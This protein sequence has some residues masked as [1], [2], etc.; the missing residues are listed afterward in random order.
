MRLTRDDRLSPHKLHVRWVRFGYQRKRD[1]EQAAYYY[2]T[3]VILIDE[4]DY[5]SC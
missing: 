5:Y 2:D 3:D 1:R 4:T